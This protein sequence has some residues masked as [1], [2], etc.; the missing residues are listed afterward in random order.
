MDLKT[1][2]Q[3]AVIRG[4]EW[5]CPPLSL[6]LCPSIYLDLQTNQRNNSLRIL[7]LNR[8]KWQT[9]LNTCSIS[10]IIS[11]FPS[12]YAQKRVDSR[13]TLALYVIRNSL[14]LQEDGIIFN[15]LLRAQY[16]YNA[17]SY[18]HDFLCM[19]GFHGSF[20]EFIVKETGRLHPQGPWFLQ[21]R[22]QLMELLTYEAVEAAVENRVEMKTRNY[23]QEV[24]VTQQ[25]DRADSLHKVEPT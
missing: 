25:D 10:D 23:G 1:G 22:A 21:D 4:P 2:L 6:A 3:K 7:S 19:D 17:N 5:N 15:L 13:Q 16:A 8:I 24:R 11:P 18:N 9:R 12:R 20:V 14:I